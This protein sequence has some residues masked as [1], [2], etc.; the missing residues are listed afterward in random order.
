MDNNLHALNDAIIL[1][2]WN[3]LFRTLLYTY[4]MTICVEL[5]V[6]YKSK[7]TGNLRRA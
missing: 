6:Y 1:Q 3:V 7:Y 5:N 4:Y 2:S